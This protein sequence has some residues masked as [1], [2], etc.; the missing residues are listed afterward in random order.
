M[1]YVSKKVS[2]VRMGKTISL[3]ASR[4]KNK[5]SLKSTGK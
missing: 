3:A 1:M 4:F 2:N 5:P